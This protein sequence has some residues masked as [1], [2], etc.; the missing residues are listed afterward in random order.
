MKN[1]KI[2]IIFIIITV[3]IAITSI[4]A[5]IN[6]KQ[7]YSQY[8]NVLNKIHIVIDKATVRM[9][10]IHDS[11]SI[12]DKTNLEVIKV[13]EDTEEKVAIYASTMPIATDDYTNTVW[14]ICN[15][16]LYPAIL[17]LRDVSIKKY[18]KGTLDIKYINKILTLIKALNDSFAIDYNKDN[19][20]LTNKQTNNISDSINSLQNQLREE[21][22]EFKSND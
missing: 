5:S 11:N 8:Y 19:K 16:E 7:V 15:N 9:S 12:T 4:K 10:Q 14:N 17:L 3:I 20:K 22:L 13:L 2:V 21:L 18:D 6:K 1:N